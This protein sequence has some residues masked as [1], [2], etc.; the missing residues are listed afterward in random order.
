MKAG[1][2]SAP[3][4]PP[5]SDRRGQFRQHVDI[6]AITAMGEIT[7]AHPELR[8]QFHVAETRVLNATTNG[9]QNWAMALKEEAPGVT[10][11]TLH[12]AAATPEHIDSVWSILEK[13]AKP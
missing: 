6:L 9:S 4:M 8:I 11:V 3:D 12:N 13:C 2:G 7:Q 1:M 5:Q 10:D